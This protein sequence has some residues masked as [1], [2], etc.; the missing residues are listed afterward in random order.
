MGK[1]GLRSSSQRAPD[2]TDILTKAQRSAL[3][4]RIR[5]VDTEPERRVR[6]LLHGL[7]LRFRLHASDLPGRPDIVLRRY[8]TALFVHG[9]FWHRHPGCAGATMPKSNRTFWS[10]KFRRNRARDRRNLAALAE[11]GWRTIVVWE[12]ELRRPAALLARLSRHFR[13]RQG[14]S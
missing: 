3:M 1:T 9:C 13:R 11:L 7:G 12:C 6:S 10:A 2:M 5:G 4:S 8:R 14:G